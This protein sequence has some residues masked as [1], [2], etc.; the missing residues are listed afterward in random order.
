DQRR[1]R[2]ASSHRAQGLLQ[3]FR[4]EAAAED[5]ARLTE[6]VD[7]VASAVEKQRVAGGD[8]LPSAK[9]P[10]ANH[11]I[12]YVAV[13]QESSAFTERQIV[14]PIGVENM[15]PVEGRRPIIETR[16]AGGEPLVSSG[17]I[18]LVQQ[19]AERV[20][21]DIVGAEV[22]AIIEPLLDVKLQPIVVVVAIRIL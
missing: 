7:R 5:H 21:P 9:R 20:T 22:Q 2:E 16:V 1:V 14:S 18:S 3:L 11:A 19:V 13:R 15:P 10:A 4:G 6:I 17:L 12:Q 8:G